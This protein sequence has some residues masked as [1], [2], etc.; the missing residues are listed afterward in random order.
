MPLGRLHSADLARQLHYLPTRDVNLEIGAGDRSASGSLWELTVRRAT[1]TAKLGEPMMRYLPELFFKLFER[2]TL[3][4][5]FFDLTLSLLVHFHKAGFA[6]R[7][8]F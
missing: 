1:P 5:S 6:L 2:K 7:V 4:P 3:K 8:S